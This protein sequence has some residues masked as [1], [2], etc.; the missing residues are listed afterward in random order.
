MSKGGAVKIFQRFLL[1]LVLVL[2]KG[3]SFA[4]TFPWEKKKTTTPAP[5]LAPAGSSLYGPSSSDLYR[6]PS[7]GGSRVTGGDL[8][9][10]S[11]SSAGSSLYRPTPA[12]SSVGVGQP[13]GAA[14]GMVPQKLGATARN[15]DEWAGDVVTGVQNY[16]RTV[17]GYI[18]QARQL[19]D[20]G[21]LDY[22]DAA[23]KFQELYDNLGYMRED[24]E[25][26]ADDLGPDYDTVLD[27]LD[28]L[29][30]I[31]NE[32]L[33]EFG[34]GSPGAGGDWPEDDFGPMVEEEF[35]D[36]YSDSDYGDYDDTL[37]SDDPNYFGDSF[38]DY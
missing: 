4:I 35:Y 23:M 19:A 29:D 3:S 21:T 11:P 2:M 18:Q 1:L 38:E 32:A 36:D 5:A 31:V 27:E 30:Q 8:Y 12:G 26:Y 20:Q 7:G 17:E 22:D 13:Y 15:I 24:L 33:N 6:Q 25:M 34:G 14:G 37:F 9:G 10:P 16:T 28:F